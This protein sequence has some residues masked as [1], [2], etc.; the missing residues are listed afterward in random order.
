[1]NYNNI[2]GHTFQSCVCVDVLGGVSCWQATPVK[3]R[4]I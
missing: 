1:M 2:V 3:L 4:Y